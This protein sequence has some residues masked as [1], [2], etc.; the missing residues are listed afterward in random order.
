MESARFAAVQH[1]RV[2]ET[3]IEKQKV[4]VEQLETAGEDTAKQI[5]RLQLLRLALAEMLIHCSQLMPSK[6]EI[7]HASK[8]A[9]LPT[10]R[11][12]WRR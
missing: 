2:M 9:P 6:E 11:E 7:A 10:A 12:R 4:L 8:T 5:R 1:V 3:R